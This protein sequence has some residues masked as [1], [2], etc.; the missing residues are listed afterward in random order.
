M[1]SKRKKRTKN[2]DAQFAEYSDYPASEDIMNRGERVLIDD[3]APIPGTE[4]LELQNGLPIDSD[5]ANVNPTRKPDPF[6][7]ERDHKEDD[8]KDRV[9]PVDYSGKDLD[10]P[11]SELDDE[12][13]KTGSEDEENNLYSRGN[14][15]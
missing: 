15:D 7:L 10:V 5:E 1:K 6:D 8:L 9:Y 13:E 3:T 11:G 12:S 14:G 2:E 4:G